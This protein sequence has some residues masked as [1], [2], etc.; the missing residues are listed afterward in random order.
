MRRDVVGLVAEQ[1]LAILE[2]DACCAEPI[3]ERV[4]EIVYPDGSKSS[5]AGQPKLSLVFR[6]RAP[7]RRLPARVVHPR[8]RMSVI[9]AVLRGEH[10][11]LMLAATAIDH[12]F[13]DPIQDD[14]PLDTVL[15]VSPGDDED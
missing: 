7:A 13:S 4:L 6:R 12:G 2:R 9:V 5:R 11:F 1:A 10:E 3:S 15:H 14:E 8:L